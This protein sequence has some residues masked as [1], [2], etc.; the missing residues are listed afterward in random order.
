MANDEGQPVKRGH[1]GEI[2]FV[3]ETPGQWDMTIGG[4]GAEYGVGRRGIE[5]ALHRRRIPY[6]VEVTLQHFDGSRET[7]PY[8]R[9]RV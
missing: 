4:R 5:D 6:G 8:E 3:E 2:L 9:G 7:I 1:K